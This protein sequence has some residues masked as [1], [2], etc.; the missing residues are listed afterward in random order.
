KSDGFS[1]EAGA[2]QIHLGDPRLEAVV[3]EPEVRGAEGVCLNYLGAGGEVGAV[4]GFDE[5]GPR[6]AELREG[7]V[8]RDAGSVEHGP[9]RAIAND[10]A[11]ADELFESGAASGAGRFKLDHSCLSF[12]PWRVFRLSEICGWETNG[13]FVLCSRLLPSP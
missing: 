6:N 11:R 13:G 1:G 10:D 5:V 9:H 2:G 8:E 7:E 3:R 4:D 12:A